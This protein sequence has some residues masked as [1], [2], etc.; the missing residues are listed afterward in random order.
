MACDKCVLPWTNHEAIGCLH[1]SPILPQVLCCPSV[2]RNKVQVL[3][4]KGPDL[5]LPEYVWTKEEEQQK[6]L[7]NGKL[8]RIFDSSDYTN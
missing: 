5:D 2:Q 4:E 7:K 3:H 1:K 6:Q 8:T